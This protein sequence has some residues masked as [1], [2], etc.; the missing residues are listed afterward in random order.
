MRWGQGRPCPYRK[1]DRL[2]LLN[3]VQAYVI[4]GGRREVTAQCLSLLGPAHHGCGWLFLWPQEG[5]RGAGVY[6]RL[7][8]V[9]ARILEAPLEARA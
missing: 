5:R 4:G 6:W 2:R 7:C 1:M 9:W 3:P 8:L